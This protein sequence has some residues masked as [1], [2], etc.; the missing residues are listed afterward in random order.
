[1]WAA[2][3]TNDSLFDNILHGIDYF[4]KLKASGNFS[5]VAASPGTVQPRQTPIVIDWDELNL[6]KGK[7][8]AGKINPK[9]GVPRVG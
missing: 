5:P 3:L 7:T 4:A 2:A 1:M 6:A 8:V 9:T